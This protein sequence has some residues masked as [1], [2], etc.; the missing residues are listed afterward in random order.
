MVIGIIAHEDCSRSRPFEIT[1]V[2]WARANSASKPGA[3]D[4]DSCA[5]RNRAR[6]R[7]HRRDARP[8]IIAIRERRWAELLPIERQLQLYWTAHCR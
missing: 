1:E 2:L 4:G 7:Q 6:G 3:T 8:S 5:S